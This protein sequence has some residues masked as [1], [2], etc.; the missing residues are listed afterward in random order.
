MKT[1]H[2]TVRSISISAMALDLLALALAFTSVSAAGSDF[3]FPY[4]SYFT[5]GGGLAFRYEEYDDGSARM[6]S[7]SSVSVPYR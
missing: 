5:T 7:G 1:L 3:V 2:H 4:P 6:S